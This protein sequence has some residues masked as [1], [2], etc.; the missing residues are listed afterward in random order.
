MFPAWNG[1]VPELRAEG[2]LPDLTDVSGEAY[3]K[4]W[5]PPVLPAGVTLPTAGPSTVVRVRFV[6]DP[7]GAVVSARVLKSPDSRLNDAALDA[8]RSWRF[9]PALDA[10]KPVASCL[11]VGVVFERPSEGRKRVPS[12]VPPLPP[13][14]VAF[15]EAVAKLMPEADYP[16]SLGDRK[17]VGDV[18][19]SGRVSTAG[20][21]ESIKILN[22][23]HADFVLPAIDALYR[24]RFTPARRGDLV[25][26]S[27]L[28]G[29]IT[30]ECSGSSR[31]E[32]LK[33]NEITAPDG[34]APDIK[35]MPLKVVDPVWP[36]DL[37]L[38]GTG[39]EASADFEVTEWGYVRDVR[40]L[41]AT[42]PEF[43]KALEA[44]LPLWR[45]E[46]PVSEGHG[47]A[48]R[49]RKHCLFGLSQAPDAKPDGL[50]GAL[51]AGR[52]GPGTGLDERLAPVYQVSP[53]YPESLRSAGHEGSAVL[54][55]VV[56]RDGRV[57]AV[58]II[59]ASEPDFGWAAAAAFSQWVFR[60]PRRH[61]QPVDVRIQVPVHFSAPARSSA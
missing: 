53:A 12:T 38:A 5:R 18:V 23:P 30:F 11:D 17:L 4:A 6:V 10:G 16:D 57:S 31:A 8:V 44:C 45:F 14:P 42:R 37:L 47:V 40:I 39:G 46:G 32:V 52:I 56:A 43:G 26:P 15:T 49:L 1:L 33:A 58:K 51:R 19:F 28:Q 3:V 61:G 21:L 54:E 13:R 34:S 55:M 2:N 29:S 41:S 20:I 50:V 35:P 36:Y 59:S 27:D 24:W 60:A 22:S 7:S 25:V 48:I 9:T